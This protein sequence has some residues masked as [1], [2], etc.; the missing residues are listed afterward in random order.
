MPEIK[1]YVSADTIDRLFALKEKQGKHD[2]TGN[3]FAA[4]LLEEVLREKQPYLPP[5]WED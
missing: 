3:E 1:F 4:E 5:T 2:L